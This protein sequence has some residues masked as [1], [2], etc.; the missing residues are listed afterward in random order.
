MIELPKVSLGLPVYNGEKFIVATL[1]S[2]INQTYTNF[3]L[4]ICDNCSTDGTEEICRGFAEKDSRITFIK[5]EKN[6]GASGNF[7]KVFNVSN[8]KYFKW[9][10]HDDVLK[11][12][13]LERCVEVLEKY[14]DVY[15]CYTKRIIIN[16]KDEELDFV[17]DGLFLN[18]NETSGRYR[19]FL[20]RF[21]YT[22]RWAIPVLG[23]FRKSEL[24]KT[25]L[26]GAYP[27][28]D[29]MILCEIALRGKLYEIDEYLFMS[30][31]H[32]QMS[33][34]AN[35]TAA[36]LAV[37]YDPKN[38]G[39]VQLP[40]WKWLIENKNSIDLAPLILSSKLK[41]YSSLFLWSIFRLKSLIVDLIKAVPQIYHLKIR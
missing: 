16:E 12:E 9:A 38:R 22:T 8:G 1:N 26:L 25:R 28:A 40:R 4:T 21:R 29:T 23:L 6:I 27:A 18:Q 20:K 13:F 10:T 35:T 14:Y 34:K 37:F 17:S 36:K 5:N 32:E 11:P 24:E 15:L 7:N 33:N 30:R 31:K 39:K 2:I 19:H 3:E 41:C